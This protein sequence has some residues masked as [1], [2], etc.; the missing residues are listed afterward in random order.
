MASE[1]AQHVKGGAS[2]AAEPTASAA[3]PT[4]GGEGATDA[5]DIGK[6]LLDEIAKLKKEQKDARDAKKE[7]SKQLRN[8]ERRRKRLKQRAKQLSDADLLAVISLRNHEKTKTLGQRDSA[9]DAE[10]DENAKSIPD[11]LVAGPGSAATSQPST[12][13]RRKKQRGS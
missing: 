6:I 13:P 11:D 3:E 12:E 5:G 10:D 2:S 1:A 7:V 9:T 8:A 4:A